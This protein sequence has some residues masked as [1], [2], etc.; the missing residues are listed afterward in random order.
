MTASPVWRGCVRR[1]RARQDQR[2][3]ASALDLDPL[4]GSLWEFGV[5]RDAHSG[6]RRAERAKK[7]LAT[8]QGSAGMSRAEALAGIGPECSFRPGT[9]EDERAAAKAPRFAVW[10]GRMNLRYAG[11]TA[12]VG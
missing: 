3:S 9:Q 10:G 7:I 11:G 4:C 1:A 8:S 6:P 5:C 2:R 12:V